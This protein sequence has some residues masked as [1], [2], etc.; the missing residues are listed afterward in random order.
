MRNDQI[1]GALEMGIM[2]EGELKA[3]L[4]LV[5]SPDVCYFGFARYV[6]HRGFLIVA[7][8]ESPISSLPFPY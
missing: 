8:P 5:Q 2:T 3:L 7:F 4:H 6:A 1:R